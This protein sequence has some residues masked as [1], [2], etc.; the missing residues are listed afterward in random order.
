L[1]GGA[2]SGAATAFSGGRE[3]GVVGAMGVVLAVDVADAVVSGAMN[4]G[5]ER[6][7]LSLSATVPG[8]VGM[9]YSLWAER[10]LSAFMTL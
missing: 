2:A 1:F 4:T 8:G 9:S 3:R 5:M 10:A 7:R 6:R